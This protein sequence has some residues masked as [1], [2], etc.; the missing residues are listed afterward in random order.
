MEPI[1]NCDWLQLHCDASHLKERYYGYTVDI[2]EV[3]TRTF[4]KLMEITRDGRRIA[5][6]QYQP[7]SPKL[8]KGCSVVK[9]ENYI[10]YSERRSDIIRQLIEDFDLTTIG[11][12]RIDIAGDFQRI[13]DRPPEELVNDILTGKVI[14]IGHSKQTVIGDDQLTAYGHRR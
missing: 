10:L 12:T 5:Q 9:I 3:R 2:R 14:R 6:I 1:I 11:T 8:P 4:A 13:A 7:H